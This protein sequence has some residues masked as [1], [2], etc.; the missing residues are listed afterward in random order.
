MRSLILLFF[1]FLFCSCAKTNTEA[2]S[3][4]IDLAL[5]Y[6]TEEKC[7]K[8]IDVLE[9]VGRDQSNAI[10]LQVLASAYACR[11]G[12]NE[13]TFLANDLTQVDATTAFLTSLTKLS[14]SPESEANSSSYNDMREAFTIL[15]QVD[16]NQPNQDNR[17]IIFGANKAA[18]M[19]IQALFLGLT[20]LGKFLHFYGNVDSTGAKGEGAASTDEQGATVSNCFIEYTEASSL[21]FLATGGGACVASSMVGHPNLSLLPASLTATKKKMCEGLVLVTNLLDILENMT[22]PSNSAFDVIR[23]LPTNL[24]AS[25]DAIIAVKGSVATLLGTT[26]QSKCEA[27]VADATEFDNLQFIYAGFFEG[28][29][30]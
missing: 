23:S 19:G 10:Y 3:E 22:L 12:F 27:V 14:L 24:V 8:A 20:Q 11:A 16:S 15:T 26:S 1:L 18:D 25:R 17:E 13:I 30:Q 4:A 9:D 2:T 28:G 7:D 21:A 5:T 29:L 6:L